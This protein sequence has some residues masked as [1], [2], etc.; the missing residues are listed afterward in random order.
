MFKG[1]WTFEGFVSR[2]FTQFAQIEK[3]AFNMLDDDVKINGFEYPHE[4]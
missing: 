3:F 1:Q 2:G 4:I